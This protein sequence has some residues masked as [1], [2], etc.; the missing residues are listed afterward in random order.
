MFSA[1]WGVSGVS[2]IR[3]RLRWAIGELKAFGTGVTTNTQQNSLLFHLSFS[4]GLFQL[5]HSSSCLPFRCDLLM[6]LIIVSLA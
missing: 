6:L 2:V 3:P 1:V 5:F 4:L